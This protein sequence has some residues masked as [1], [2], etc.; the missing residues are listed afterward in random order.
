MYINNWEVKLYFHHIVI[1]FMVFCITG[2]GFVYRET[3]INLYNYINY[4]R[5]LYNLYNYII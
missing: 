2:C 1:L 5:L 4:L 3:I